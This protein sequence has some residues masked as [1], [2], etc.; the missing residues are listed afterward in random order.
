MYNFPVLR[1]FILF[2]MMTV[3]FKFIYEKSS[4][5]KCIPTN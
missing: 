1:E 3:D 2:A 5:G 4:H